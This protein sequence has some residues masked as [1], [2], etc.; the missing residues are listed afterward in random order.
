M[1]EAKID[2]GLRHQGVERGIA[3]ESENVVSKLPH[4]AITFGAESKKN[5]EDESPTWP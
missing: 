5:D 4:P 2:S 3:G 1:M